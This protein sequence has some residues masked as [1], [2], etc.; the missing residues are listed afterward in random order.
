MLSGRRS[1]RSPAIIESLRLRFLNGDNAAFEELLSEY[2]PLLKHISHKYCSQHNEREDCLAEAVLGFLRAVRTYNPE[3]GSLDS[4]VMTVSSHRLIDMVRHADRGRVVLSDDLD[5]R[6]SLL[7]DPGQGCMTDIA[8]LNDALSDLERQCFE[9]YLR[10]ESLAGIAAA[11]DTT[12][13]SVSNAL[14]RAKRKLG[15]GLR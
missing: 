13:A 9:R 3:K 14:S 11:L 12:K 7:G 1:A 5:K 15:R 10:G 6:E 4:Y 2:M 8:Q